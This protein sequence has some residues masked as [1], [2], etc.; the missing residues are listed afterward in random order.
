MTGPKQKSAAKGNQ[1][2]SATFRAHG[3]LCSLSEGWFSWGAGTPSFHLLCRRGRFFSSGWRFNN[4]GSAAYKRLLGTVIAYGPSSGFPPPPNATIP[5]PITTDDLA[6]QLEP[7]VGSAF[8]PPHR[9]VLTSSSIC[10]V[11]SRIPRVLAAPPRHVSS[12]HCRG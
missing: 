10:L 7:N 4:P 8:A 11:A 6:S 3:G 9:A 5:Q 2:V 1:I 12:P